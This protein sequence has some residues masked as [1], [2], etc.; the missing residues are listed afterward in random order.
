MTN[1][2]IGAVAVSTTLGAALAA[3][4]FFAFSTFVMAA[5]GRLLPE[6]GIAA[7]QSI[8]VVVVNPWF[9]GVF[10]G[11]ALGAIALGLLGFVYWGAPGSTYLVA[12]GLIYVIGCF[13]VT[14][15]FNIPL[16]NALAAVEPGSLAGAE[17]WTRFLAS[18]TGWNH[19]RTVASLAAAASFLLALR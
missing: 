4:I 11:T 13:L 12:G 8:N 1:D 6:Q 18:W 9:L 3:G 15:A 19:V 10:L 17:L 7:M 14:V 2:L 5:L 16:N